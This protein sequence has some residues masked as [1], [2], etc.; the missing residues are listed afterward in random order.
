MD[1]IS[2]GFLAAKAKSLLTNKWVW[3]VIA[4]LGVAIVGYNSFHNFVNKKVDTAVVTDRKD[5]TIA[6]YKANEKVDEAVADIDRQHDV[7][8]EQ[9]I[10]EYHYVREQI[11]AAPIEQREEAAP[12]L[13]LDTLNA[14]GGMR[15]GAAGTDPVPETTRPVG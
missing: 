2:I 15:R 6:T 12:D 1:P 7:I 11:K 4:A 5:A 9:T 10:K 3:I 8:R 13:L 14:L